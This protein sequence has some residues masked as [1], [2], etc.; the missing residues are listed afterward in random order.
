MVDGALAASFRPVAALSAVVL[1]G[2]AWLVLAQAG[3]VGAGP[4]G[5]TV[6]RRATWAVLGLLGLN[7]WPTSRAPHPVER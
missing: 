6:V 2:I 3:V 4:F 1:F 5:D 7:T